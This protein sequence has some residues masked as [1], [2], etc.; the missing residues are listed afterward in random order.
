MLDL[1]FIRQNQEK[2]KKSTQEKGVDPKLVGQLLEVDKKRRELINQVEKL[3]QERNQL[4]QNLKEKPGTKNNF[5]KE[6][7]SAFGKAALVIDSMFI[8][9]SLVAIK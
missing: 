8:I 4:N 9:F 5:N 7:S 3:K 2:I 6:K 1:A